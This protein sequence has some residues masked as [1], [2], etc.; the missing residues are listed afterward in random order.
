M[1]IDVSALV[2]IL[3]CKRAAGGEAIVSKGTRVVIASY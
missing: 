3:W 2:S 1:I